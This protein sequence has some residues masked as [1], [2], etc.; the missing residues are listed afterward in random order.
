MPDSKVQLHPELQ[1]WLDARQKSLNIVKTTTTPTGRTLDW[2]PIESQVPSGKIATPP[3]AARAL[4]ETP[5]VRPAPIPQAAAQQ[6]VKPATFELDDPNVERGPAGTVPILRPDLSHFAGLN[7]QQF[8]SKTKKGGLKV[9]PNRPKPPAEDPN[10]AGYFHNTD[11]QSVRCYGWDGRLNVWDPAIN[12]PSGGNGEDHSILQVWLQNYDKPQLQSLEGGLTV[13]QSLNG[14]TQPHVFTYYTVNGY[15][16]DGDNQGG[17]NRLHKGWVQY[18][19]SVFP[20]IRVNGISV[21]DGPQYDIGMK[22]QLYKEPNSNDVNWWV[23]VQGIWMGYYPASLY[24]GGLGTIV[25]WCGSGGEIYSGLPNPEQTHDQMGSGWQASGGWTRAAFLRNLRIQTDMNGDMTD[26]NGTATSDA[27]TPGGADPYT[28]A[29]DMRSGSSWGSYF[30]VGG[31]TPVPN[32]AETFDEIIFDIV[33]GGDDLRGDSTAVATVAL[34][35]GAQTFTLKAQNESGWGNNSD[36]VKSFHISGN[37]HPLSDFSNIVITLTSHNGF[38]ETD[39][40]WN[41]QSLAVTLN[42]SGSPVTYLS[43]SGNPLARLTGSSP[44]VTLHP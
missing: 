8:L 39:D 12:I 20:G 4:A 13:D 19:S 25:E 40:N 30:Y 35:S 27:A 29:L 14:D 36:H 21:F 37:A 2:V 41:I 1:N 28:I 34:P 23:S 7:L 6:D 31:P 5:G 11:S 15:T 26:N 17:Y 22:F 42:G 24:S 9:N 10:P 16:S 44:S 33:T 38:L 32:L 18:S 43:K 3:V